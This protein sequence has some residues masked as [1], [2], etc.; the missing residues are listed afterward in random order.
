MSILT[1]DPT[2]R[3]GAR[4]SGDDTPRVARW[5]GTALLTVAGLALLVLALAFYAVRQSGV[6]VFGGVSYDTTIDTTGGGA[7]PAPADASRSGNTSSSTTS[8]APDAGTGGLGS[9]G[10]QPA[11]PGA[12]GSTNNGVNPSG[13]T[14]SGV[15]GGGSGTAGG[16][17]GGR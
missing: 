10:D 2:V 9:S 11:A 1:P 6:G 8:R 15:P 14:T 3:D 4:P 7:Q 5:S 16:Y 13:G 12:S 17:G